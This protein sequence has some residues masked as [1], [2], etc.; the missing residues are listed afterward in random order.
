MSAVSDNSDSSSCF[1][2]NNLII[3]VIF[4]HGLRSLIRKLASCTA[5]TGSDFLYE[6]PN[7]FIMSFSLPDISLE[8]VQKLQESKL[9][10]PSRPSPPCVVLPAAST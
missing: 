7:A 4:Y 3:F 10:F 6:T 1:F 2:G 9:F 5:A 8:A